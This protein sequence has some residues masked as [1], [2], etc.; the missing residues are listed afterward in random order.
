MILSGTVIVPAFLHFKGILL[1][2]SDIS[3]VS[4]IVHGLVIAV[5]GEAAAKSIIFLN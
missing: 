5:I 4:E 2:L 1:D 3:F